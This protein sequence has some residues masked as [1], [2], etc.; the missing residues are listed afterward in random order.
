[1]D[2]GPPK[3]KRMTNISENMHSPT[4]RNDTFFFESKR[5]VF[6]LPLSA[7]FICLSAF[8]PPNINGIGYYIDERFPTYQDR[9]IKYH[10]E[11]DDGHGI[12]YVYD[13]SQ[14]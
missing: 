13:V 8:S 9:N 10:K 12:T 14:I 5:Y 7:L 11:K 4:L 2:M 1:M 6:L 3:S